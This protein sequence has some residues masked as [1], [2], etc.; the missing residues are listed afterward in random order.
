MHRRTVLALLAFACLTL[1]A[2][3]SSAATILIDEN[4]VV[5]ANLPAT[6]TTGV[7]QVCEFLQNLITTCTTGSDSDQLIFTT[8]FGG[9]TVTLC[10]NPDTDDTVDSGCTL[11]AAGTIAISEGL[12]G[13]FDYTP[14]PGTPGFD[15][16]LG[17][18]QNRFFF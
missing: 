9:V 10:S 5:Q 11:G 6:A 13:G 15:L 8:V 1:F 12:F 2:P 7:V 17:G 16:T 3:A 4:V 14:T 18:N